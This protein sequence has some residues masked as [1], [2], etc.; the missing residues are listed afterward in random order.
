MIQSPFVT[1]I[2]RLI[3]SIIGSGQKLNFY[4]TLFFPPP[5]MYLWTIEGVGK[6]NLLHLSP[7]GISCWIKIYKYAKLGVTLIKRGKDRT[8][9]KSNFARLVR[10]K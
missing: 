8:I 5:C 10:L 3:A 4:Q 7:G 2:R 9:P 6:R 1:T